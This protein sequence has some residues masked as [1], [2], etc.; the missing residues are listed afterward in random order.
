MCYYYHGPGRGTSRNGGAPFPATGQPGGGSFFALILEKGG[1]GVNDREA[2]FCEEYLID[3]DAPAAALRAG[4]PVKAARAAG[5]W[6]KPGSGRYRPRLHAGVRTRM[7][8]RSRRIGITAERVLREYARIAFAS[9]E[10]V[11][12]FTDGVRPRTD[13]CADDL[14]AVASVKYKR[15]SGVDCE[16]KM[17]DKLKALEVLGRHLGLFEAREASGE[18]APTILVYPDGSAA[19]AGG[20][21]DEKAV[22]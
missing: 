8:E 17:Y 22:E 14:A 13:T 20:E 6:L 4:Y 11:A 7:A 1:G 2:R 21:D 9:I 15:G 18:A 5:D 16:I 12:D 3:L 10:D 19:I